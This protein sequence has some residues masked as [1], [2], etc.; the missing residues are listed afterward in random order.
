MNVTKMLFLIIVFV[1]PLAGFAYGLDK[2]GDIRY[3][4]ERQHM[5]YVEKGYGE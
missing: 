3:A 4:I 5:Q 2:A 1:M